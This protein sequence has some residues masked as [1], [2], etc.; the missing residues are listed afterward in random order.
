MNRYPP[1][2]VIDAAIK[3]SNWAASVDLKDYSIYGIGPIPKR[4]KFKLYDRVR[5]IHGSSWRGKVVGFYATELTP[6]GY[7]VES[8]YEPGSVQIYPEGALQIVQLER[9][10]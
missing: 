1:Q 6:I 9:G 10:V 2:E 7:A 5:K 8:E 3:I 4:G